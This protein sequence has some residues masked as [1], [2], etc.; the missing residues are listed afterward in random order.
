[1]NKLKS[2]AFANVKTSLKQE[3]EKEYRN[4]ILQTTT[5]LPLSYHI[6]PPIV[7]I[8]ICLAQ[9]FHILLLFDNSHSHNRKKLLH[10]KWQKK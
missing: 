10:E 7:F 2:N 4:A 5:K 1:M 3:Q 6:S 9:E 8:P